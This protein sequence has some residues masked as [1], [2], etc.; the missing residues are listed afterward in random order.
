MFSKKPSIVLSTYSLSFISGAQTSTTSSYT[1]RTRS[2]A[3]RC[4]SNTY[5]T[6]AGDSHGN[7]E[8]PPSD[9]SSNNLPSWPT[10]P[11]GHQHPTP[12]QIFALPTTAPYTK[13]RFYE[14]VKLYH[15][16]LHKDSPAHPCHAL[17]S[18]ARLERYRLIV[19]AH[20]ILSDPEKRKAYDRF[21]AGWSGKSDASAY[22]YNRGAGA[23][24]FSS[25]YDG[26]DHRD[27]ND[28][29]WN[30]AT[31]ED[32]ESWREKTYYGSAGAG[33]APVYFRNSYFLSVVVMMAILGST[34]NTSR[35]EKAGQAFMA[36]KDAMHDRAAKELRKV[37]QERQGLRDK[38]ERIEWF[39]RQREAS[40]LGIGVE[41]MMEEKA[42]RVL[43][44]GDVCSSEDLR[45][46][47]TRGLVTEVG[48]YERVA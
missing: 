5:A 21:G 24:P 10:P 39:A 47:D 22:G 30:N 8:P 19:A 33:Q 46:S 44:Q 2:P 43:P 6:I 3:S 37:R 45:G 9:P 38:E 32:W 17:P 29:I 31:W 41:E 23:G 12:Y 26:R 35:A 25:G 16:D 7:Q 1:P 4:P 42:R 13:S 18:T 48:K 40:M 20:S 28:P 14:L 36:E 34:A 11:T 15:P 27:F